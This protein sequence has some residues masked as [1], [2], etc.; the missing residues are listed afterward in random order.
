MTEDQYTTLR[1]LEG[2]EVSL[3][4]GD[5]SRIDAAALMSAG[6]DAG[7]TVWLFSNGSDLFIPASDVR[8]AWEPGV[9]GAGAV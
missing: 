2:R 4:L 5:G 3:A 1:R 8:D 6:Q 9:P 7:S